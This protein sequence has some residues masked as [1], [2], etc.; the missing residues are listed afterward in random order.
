MFEIISTS[1]DDLFL[2]LE[3]I[4]VLSGAL[5]FSSNRE[6]HVQSAVANLTLKPPEPSMFG[7]IAYAK[8]PA[9]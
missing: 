9:V 7:Y 6:H 1:A 3:D 4:C 2:K 5:A 8:C